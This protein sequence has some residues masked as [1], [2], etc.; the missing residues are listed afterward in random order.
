MGDLQESERPDRP[1]AIRIVGAFVAGDDLI[2][3]LTKQGQRGMTNPFFFA[4]II[5]QFRKTASRAGETRRY[6]SAR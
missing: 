4:R 5:K 3:T 2:D 1:Q 6:R